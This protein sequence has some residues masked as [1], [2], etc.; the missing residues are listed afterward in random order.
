M[1]LKPR[2]R[3]VETCSNLLARAIEGDIVHKLQNKI[4]KTMQNKNM[5]KVHL[6]TLKLRDSKLPTL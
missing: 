1:Q 6:V 3:I 2:V 4:C 5:K